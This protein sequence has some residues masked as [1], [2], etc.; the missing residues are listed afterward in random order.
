MWSRILLFTAV[1]RPTY[2]R[3]YPTDTVGIIMPFR[4]VAGMATDAIVG[5]FH[6]RF[7][8]AFQCNNIKTGFSC[9][10][11]HFFKKHF[12][13]TNTGKHA[14]AQNRIRY[15]FFPSVV[16]MGIF[17]TPIRKISCFWRLRTSPNTCTW[18][19]PGGGEG[20]WLH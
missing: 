7:L 12:S 11:K 16:L 17:S 9:T 6:P 3:R 13:E 18:S 4:T 2:H 5:V 20:T 15:Y 14:R 1:P 19:R 10:K 8:I